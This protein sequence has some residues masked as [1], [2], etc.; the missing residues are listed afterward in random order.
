VLGKEEDIAREILK[1]CDAGQ[2]KQAWISQEAPD[3]VP[4]PGTPQPVV[5]PPVG[6]PVSGMSAQQKELLQEL[7]S[8]YLRNVP[9]D[10]AS[11]RRR[12]INAAGLDKVFFAWWGESEPNQRHHYRVQ[13]PTFV[14]EYNNTQNQANHVHSM[15]RSIGGDFHRAVN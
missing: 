3:E 5:G 6:L 9:E 7:L 2:Q 13:G 15:W 10:V 1:L 11:E 12:E 8:E 14:I 4:G